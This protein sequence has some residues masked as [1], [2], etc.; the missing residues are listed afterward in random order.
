MCVCRRAVWIQ[1][2]PKWIPETTCLRMLSD[3]NRIFGEN[4]VRRSFH[5]EKEF[6]VPKDYTN[7]PQKL[8]VTKSG[9]VQCKKKEC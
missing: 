1:Y 9:L 2:L 5:S 4:K 8:T 3:A 7:Y 6:E